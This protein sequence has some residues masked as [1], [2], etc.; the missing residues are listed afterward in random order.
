MPPIQATSNSSINEL[1]D[2]IDIK[3]STAEGP[4][5]VKGTLSTP[6]HLV[7]LCVKLPDGRRIQHQFNCKQDRLMD[8]ICFAHSRTTS[9]EDSPVDLDSIHLSDNNVPVHVYS[10]YS[11]TLFEA[12][13]TH[14]T[15]LHFS[16]DIDY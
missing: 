6:D 11:L 4:L 1:K 8:V 5:L 14:N 15:L 3:T 7:T 2:S 13:L 9:G 12:G 16:C 10:D